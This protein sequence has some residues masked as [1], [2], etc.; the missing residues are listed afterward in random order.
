MGALLGDALRGR[1]SKEHLERLEQQKAARLVR[2][3]E[4]EAA[5]EAAQQQEREAAEEAAR[6]EAAKLTEAEASVLR[7]QAD[8]KAHKAQQKHDDAQNLRLQ[9]AKAQGLIAL[10]KGG[11]L[12]ARPQLMR[13][14]AMA[15]EL[16]QV[17]AHLPE[18]KRPGQC[19]RVSM[20]RHKHATTREP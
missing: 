15:E 3:R 7:A 13:C 6:Q 9:F 8:M 18:T 1:Y 17:R 10:G 19:E 5:R 2:D 20:L 14:K 4:R 12:K 11:C 16:G